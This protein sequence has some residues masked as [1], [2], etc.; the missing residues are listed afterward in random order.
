MA[1]KARRHHYIP[2]C[3]LRGFLPKGKKPKLTVL[4]LTEKRTFLEQPEGVCAVHDFNQVKIDG[5]PPDSLENAWSESESGWAD[6]LRDLHKARTLD[7][8]TIYRTIMT[9][10]ALFAVR[11]PDV[12]DRWSQSMRQLAN[13]ILATTLARKE[14]YE[15]TLTAMKKRGAGIPCDIPYE[16]V[17]NSFLNG[18]TEIQVPTES[19]LANE[20]RGINSIYPLLCQRGWSLLIAS[21]GAGPFITCDN[22]VNLGWKHS[23]QIPAARRNSPGFGCKD[24]VVVFSVSQSMAV[25]GDFEIENQVL[26]VGS[27]EV[28]TINSLILS[29]AVHQVYAPD[30]SFRLIN[31][32]GN[33]IAG[34]DLVGS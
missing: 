33:L 25:V 9:L 15:A 10:I 1:K 2:Q 28:A 34:R 21:D 26:T 18:D 13:L 16:E 14:Q 5:L 30:A 19:H 4:D 12:R 23:E 32:K 11:N 29:G 8:E 27:N 24:T 20:F 6:A 17:R 22:P 3:Y 31:N 7:N